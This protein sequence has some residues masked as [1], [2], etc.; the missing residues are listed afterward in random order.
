MYRERIRQIYEHL[1]AGYRRI[2]DYVLSHYREVA[3]MTAAELARA[4]QVDTT[5]VVRFAQR[6]GYRGYPELV[7]EIRGEVKQDLQSLYQPV[8]EDTPIL[9]AFRTCLTEDRNNLEYALLHNEGETIEQVVNL[10]V[11][12]KRIIVVAEGAAVYPAQTAVMRLSSLGRNAYILPM[13]MVSRTTMLAGAEQG[14]LLLGIGVVNIAVGVDAA[15]GLARKRGAWTVGIVSTVAHPIA[16][17]V[18]HLL[19]APSTGSGLNPSLTAITAVINALVYTVGLQAG[20]RSPE[21]NARFD[22]FYG[23]MAGAIQEAARDLPQVLADM[24][25]QRRTRRWHDEDDS[26]PPVQPA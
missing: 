7:D 16:K 10:M 6:L 14:D 24:R 2:A 1:S 11:R 5:L 20:D 3:F 8:S 4:S 21:W 23:V 22:E 17:Q 26:T 12:A 25:G 13:D 9:T 15:M 18:Q 19:T